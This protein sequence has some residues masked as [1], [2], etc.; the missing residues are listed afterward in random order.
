MDISINNLG[1]FRD[2]HG[3]L[4]VLGI[5]VDNLV[6]LKVFG[7]YLRVFGEYL[8]VFR[9]YLGEFERI[10]SNLGAIGKYLGVFRVYGDI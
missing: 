8:R 9:G 4:G 7:E 10:L 2:I 6:Y 1:V 5:I 3:K